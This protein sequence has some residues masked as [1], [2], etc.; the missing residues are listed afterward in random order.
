[1]PN[2]WCVLRVW[3]CRCVESYTVSINFNKCCN[4]LWDF[5]AGTQ[6]RH[7]NKLELSRNHPLFHKMN[8]GEFP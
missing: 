3:V 6:Q 5:L 1:M 8:V 7:G 2:P 4:L